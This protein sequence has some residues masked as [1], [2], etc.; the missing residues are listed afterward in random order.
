[1]LQ[2]AELWRYHACIMEIVTRNIADV[3]HCQAYVYSCHHQMSE[4]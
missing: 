1:M 2:N 3:Q 4:S